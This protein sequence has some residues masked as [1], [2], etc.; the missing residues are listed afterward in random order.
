MQVVTKSGTNDFSGNL[1]EYFRD[2]SLNAKGVFETEKPEY[3]RHQFG[4]SLGGPILRDKAHFFGAAERTQVDEFYT[5]STGLPQFY[6]SVEGTFAKPF[7][8]NLYFGRVDWQ[9]TN[10]QNLFIRYAQEDERSTCGGC[11]GT[12]ASSAGFDQETPRRSIVVGPGIVWIS[13]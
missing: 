12:T 2:K 10:P 5:V 7:H 9:A 8:R 1:F 11:G 3:Q 13:R 4:G 6:S